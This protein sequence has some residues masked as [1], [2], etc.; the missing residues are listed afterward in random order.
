MIAVLMVLGL[1]A[2]SSS[3]HTGSKMPEAVASVYVAAGGALACGGTGSA[4]A[5]IVAH[6]TL[7]CGT[8]VRLCYPPPPATGSR[9]VVATVRDR[10]PYVAGRTFDLAMATANALHFPDGYGPVGYAVLRR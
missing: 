1:L 5:L 4:S 8:R 9:C 7:A 6:K 3:A 10:G 2:S